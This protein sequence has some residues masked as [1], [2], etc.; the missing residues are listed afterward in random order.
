MLIKRIFIPPQSIFTI[1]E[2]YSDV[3]VVESARQGARFPAER[4]VAG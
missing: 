4:M 3:S 2:F 1:K